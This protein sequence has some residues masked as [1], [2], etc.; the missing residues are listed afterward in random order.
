MQIPILSR[1]SANDYINLILTYTILIVEP[2]FRLA[3]S[4][5]GF[6]IPA[7]FLP[8]YKRSGKGETVQD[9]VQQAGYPFEPHYSIT[10]GRFDALM[11]VNRD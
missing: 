7:S 8:S 11:H 2:F 10:R 9:Y 4:I 3:L 1:L 5:L 6:V